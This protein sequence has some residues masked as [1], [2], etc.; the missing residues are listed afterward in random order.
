[1]TGVEARQINRLPEARA[2]TARVFGFQELGLARNRDRLKFPVRNAHRHVLTQSYSR[3]FTRLP[4]RWRF[5]ASAQA[6]RSAPEQAGQ[7]E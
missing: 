6:R 3:G 7:I 4:K 1:M 5:Q 2:P